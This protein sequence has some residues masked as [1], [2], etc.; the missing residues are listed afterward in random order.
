VNAFLIALAIAAAASVVACK[1]PLTDPTAPSAPAE[2]ILDSSIE[3]DRLDQDLGDAI[4]VI[5]AAERT[6]SYFAGLA[7]LR[8]EIGQLVK[9]GTQ[10][11]FSKMSV[12]D[13][14]MLLFMLLSQDAREDTKELLAEM[15]DT[16]LER[17]ALRDAAETMRDELSKLEQALRDEY[18]ELRAAGGSADARFEPVK[19]Q[20]SVVIP[21]SPSG[22]AAPAREIPITVFA[23]TGQGASVVASTQCA[24][25]DG[26]KIPPMMSVEL[27]DVSTRQV[28]SSHSGLGNFS[29]DATVAT[30]GYYVVRIGSAGASA[31]C[32]VSL[33]YSS[34]ARGP[35]IELS[36]DV[37]DLAKRK[38]QE[39]E[40]YEARHAAAVRNWI[41]SGPQLDSIQLVAWEDK[42]MRRTTQLGATC[43]TYADA[44]SERDKLT[45]Q[46]DSISEMNQMDML[47]LQQMMEKKGQ[48]ESLI[49]NTMKSAS[50]AQ[51]S[52]VSALKAS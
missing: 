30:G 24:S 7:L 8:T 9:H 31:A 47:M 1:D 3:L 50:D 32:P 20:I 36:A 27:L 10:L 5:P 29:L 2:R 28:I 52:V 41:N 51:Q 39:V 46:K 43:M 40:A 12:E 21:A 15:N 49:S 33:S 4:D 13:A 22:Q 34:A 23:P 6:E 38:Q 37:V 17:K 35:L 19:T 48:L 18:E 26:T 25:A 42:L 16:R 45:T 14:A 44:K 11:D